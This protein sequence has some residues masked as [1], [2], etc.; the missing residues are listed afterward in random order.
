MFLTLDFMFRVDIKCLEPNHDIYITEQTSAVLLVGVMTV[1]IEN[2]SG[3]LSSWAEFLIN[4]LM[5]SIT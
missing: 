3:F 2:M 4:L 1:D 5:L